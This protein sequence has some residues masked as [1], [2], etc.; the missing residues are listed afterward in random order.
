MSET[1]SEIDR[2]ASAGVDRDL[3]W[4]KVLDPDELPEGRVKSVSCGA[5]TLCVT[6]FEGGYAA[7]D[8]K[9]PA[10]GWPPGRGFDRERIAPLS[11]A[12]V[13]LRSD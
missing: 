10:P 9:C 5:E 3:V 7:L 1:R 11:L 13:G 6:H 4:Q 8:N 12:R 2:G